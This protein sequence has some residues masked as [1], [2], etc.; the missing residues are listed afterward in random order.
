MDKA[1]GSM[2]VAHNIDSLTTGLKEMLDT[3]KNYNK[4]NIRDFAINH[5]S[6]N[7]IG[8]KFIELYHQVLKT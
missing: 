1:N 6:Y 7:V 4:S 2:I 3:L 8:L 5:F